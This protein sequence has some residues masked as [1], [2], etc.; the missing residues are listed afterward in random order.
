MPDFIETAPD[1]AFDNPEV[2]ASALDVA[3]ADANTVHSPSAWPEAIGALQEVAFGDGF[4][5]HFEQHLHRSVTDGADSQR[6]LSA[7]GFGYPAAASRSGLISPA[8]EF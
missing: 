8:F 6:A 4:D 1:V 2:L 5:E 7:F 3:S